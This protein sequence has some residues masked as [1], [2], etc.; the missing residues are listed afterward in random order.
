MAA[1]ISR[2]NSLI[3]AAFV[4]A[5]ALL[6]ILY[7]RYDAEV[8]DAQFWVDHTYRVEV[9]IKDL[10]I[11]LD[12]AEG[13]Q[14]AYLLTGRDEFLDPYAAARDRWGLLF[15]ELKGLTAD[16]PA[17]QQRLDGLSSLMQ[18]RFEGLAQTIEA[19]RG[20]GLEAAMAL[21]IA[22]NGRQ[23]SLHIRD[24]LNL[25]L[26]SENDLLSQRYVI[27]RQNHATT[28]IL[29]I[30]GGLV[31]ALLLALGGWLVRRTER[32]RRRAEAAVRDAA[33]QLRLSF[34]SLSQGIAVFDNDLCL[35]N[36]NQCL[37]SLLG[38][39]PELL[40][41]GASYAEI[42]HALRRENDFLETPGEVAET[43]TAPGHAAPVVFR[44][45]WEGDRSFEL[46]RTLLPGG[47]FAITVTDITLQVRAEELQRN[48]QKMRALGELTG[49]VAHDFNN[50]L[51]VIGGNL[52]LLQ[53][54]QTLDADARRY[55]ASALRGV[56]RGSSLTQHLL[57]FGRRS[58]LAPIPIDLNRLTSEMTNGMLRRALG[59]RVDLKLVE[60]AGLWPAYADPAQLENALLNLAINARDAMPDG[61]KLTIE[62]ANVTFD[63][64]YASENEE[65]T[66]GQYVMVAV[67]DT[68][69]GM[70]PDVVAR[71]FEPFYTTKE[72]GKG[73][74][75]GLAMVHG[76]A[77]QSRGH[78]KLYSEVGNGTTV[79]LYLPRSQHNAVE[80]PQAPIHMP[81][82]DATVLVVEDD[83]DV[84][85]V[86]VAQLMDLG[87]RVFEAGDAEAGLKIFS[88]RGDI[89]LLLTDVVLPGRLRGRELADLVRRVSPHTAI[90]FMSG[91]TENAIVH[92]GKL[93]EGTLLLQKPFRREE[94]AKKVA[95]A[96]NLGEAQAETDN[97]VRLP[98]P[99]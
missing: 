80:Q 56:S 35:A 40:V 88:A 44:R 17:E 54:N 59:E 93:D 46:R 19:R 66:P 31:A 57:A 91:Y 64:R 97:I 12:E 26:A 4:A 39:K 23:I 32:E 87:Y 94:L 63:E 67:S 20:R 43:I 25:M 21:A 48:T 53:H 72:E 10:L 8:R 98:P 75:L 74:G 62:T 7:F 27:V 16:N 58:P 41:R 79:K 22:N 84:R 81:R 99:R 9:H 47:G 13:G 6:A 95:L 45:Q 51:T 28:V 37:Q 1:L 55:V 15:S 68:G 96:L 38:L 83:P 18:R 36:W 69:S 73:S 90:L 76:F 50:L 71:A 65:V 34:D 61:G 29:M 14:R 24:I 52:D 33:A 77:K 30:V 3:I 2:A 49:G 60:S 42:V 86:A 82:G 85:R 78:I 92:D 89:D 11:A 5:F 70:P